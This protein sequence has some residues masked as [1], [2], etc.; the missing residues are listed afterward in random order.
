MKITDENILIEELKKG[1]KSAFTSLYAHYA[2]RIRAFALRWTKN[3]MYAEDLTQ[4][5]FIRLWK[6]R[7]NI[8]QSNSIKSFLFTIASNSLINAYHKTV[9]SPIFEDYLKHIDSLPSGRSFDP[10]E[11][12]HFLEAINRF[13]EKMPASRCRIVKLSKLEG[14]SNKEISEILSLKEQTVKNQLSI[15]VKELREFIIA[16]VL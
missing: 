13:I 3:S 5:V 4:E 11:Y 1:S 15:G 14:Y 10:L 7:E 12:S 2:P 16:N 6:E 9:N 8:R